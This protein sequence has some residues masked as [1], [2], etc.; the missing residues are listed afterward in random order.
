MVE[1]DALTLI[2]QAS[3]RLTAS[4]LRVAEAILAEAP[5]LV[6]VSI[7]ELAERGRTSVSTVARF[8]QTLGYSGYRELQSAVSRSVTLTQARQDRFGLEGSTIT[9]D[10]PIATVAAKVGVQQ[11]DA[12]EKTTR[13]LDVDA[14]ERAANAILDARRIS[15]LGH[16]ASSLAAQDLQ[17]K[18]SRIGLVVSHSSD[19]HLALTAASLSTEE[20]VAI[21]FSHSGA[22]AEVI[23]SLT[24][25]RDAGATAIA[26]T[27]EAGSKLAQAADIVLLTYAEESPFRMAAKSSRI[28]QLTIVDI[29]F[30]CTVQRS[31]RSVFTSLQLTHDAV[32]GGRGSADDH[33]D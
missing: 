27:N 10:D 2:R 25:A 21:G 8:A 33:A 13:M 1:T 4:E 17:Q 3:D 9:P 18:L 30:V 14:L 11:V 7:T 26:V 12:V 29:L 32:A 31:N 22:T 24:V 6:G 15:T 19:P 16:G 5:D 28:A 20:D 23:R